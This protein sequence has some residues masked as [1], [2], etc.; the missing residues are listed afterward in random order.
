MQMLFLQPQQQRFPS[1]GKTRCRRASESSELLS[2]DHLIL[3]CEGD[4]ILVA[5]LPG[6]LPKALD[7][8]IG[9]RQSTGMYSPK[10][11]V[12]TRCAGAVLDARSE[13]TQRG[14]CQLNL[15]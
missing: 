12:L 8:G 5:V 13:S 7:Y 4:G 6:N 1:L 14:L 15:C 2:G 3:R 9:H 10:R 11:Q